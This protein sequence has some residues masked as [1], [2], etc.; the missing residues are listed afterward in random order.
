[1]AVNVTSVADVV[2]LSRRYP[3]LA[4]R[5]TSR[6]T[7]LANY[8]FSELR[9]RAVVFNFFGTTVFLKL[10]LKEFY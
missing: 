10:L 9:L 2:G 8:Y 4:P 7:L 5:L 1:M 6:M 3:I